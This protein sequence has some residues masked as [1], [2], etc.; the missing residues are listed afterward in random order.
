MITIVIVVEAYAK[1]PLNSVWIVPGS[2]ADFDEVEE[3]NER[4]P[5]IDDYLAE[6]GVLIQAKISPAEAETLAV[7]L[8]DKFTR[9]DFEVARTFYCND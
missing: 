7:H 1:K 8:V 6:R 2:T 9:A 3:C 5:H 4:Y